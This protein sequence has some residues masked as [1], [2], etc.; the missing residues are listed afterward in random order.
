MLL[1][2]I[3]MGD[4]YKYVFDFTCN[5][6]AT[7]ISSVTGEAL[8]NRVCICMYYMYQYI[9]TLLFD[10]LEGKL[11]LFIIYLLFLYQTMIKYNNVNISTRN[12]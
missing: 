6:T 1:L 7:S 9:L 3:L 12:D 5:C 11:L 10:F 4:T 8:V 2:L